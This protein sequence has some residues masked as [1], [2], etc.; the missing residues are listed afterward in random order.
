MY[1][2]VLIENTFADNRDPPRQNGLT[3]LIDHQ[4]IPKMLSDSGYDQEPL[5]M[6][7]GEWEYVHWA[8]MYCTRKRL[9]HCEGG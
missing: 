3:A 7:H 2:G 6:P 8:Q 1:A 5:E 4:Y 9:F